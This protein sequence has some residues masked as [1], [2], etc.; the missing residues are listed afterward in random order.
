MIL[1]V[2]NKDVA[3]RSRPLSVLVSLASERVYIRQGFEP[4][5]EAE[6][7]IADAAAS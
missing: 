5:L 1:R 7:E 2:H 3:R 6:V 4:I